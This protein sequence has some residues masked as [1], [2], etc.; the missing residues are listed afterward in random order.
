MSRRMVLLCLLIPWVPGI[1][2]PNL[3]SAEAAQPAAS[4]YRLQK[5]VMG[6]AGAPA[7]SATRKSYTTLGQPTPIGAAASATKK[8]W[9]G[10]WSGTYTLVDVP[11]ETLPASFANQLDGNTP[12]PFFTATKI[13]Y[14]LAQEAR[15]RLAVFDVQGRSMRTLAD[16]RQPPG[17]HVVVWDGSDDLGARV[18]PGVYLYCLRAGSYT[19]VKKLVVVR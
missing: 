14:S 7:A 10:F 5:S 15:V 3:S 19:S 17:R 18:S 12:N 13:A 8:L 16:T 9:A 4:L 6:A 1:G 2:H 11:D